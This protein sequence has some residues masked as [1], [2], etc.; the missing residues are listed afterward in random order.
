[1]FPA[2]NTMLVEL[3][4]WPISKAKNHTKVVQDAIEM[5]MNME[6]RGGCGCEPETGDG[7]GILIQNPHE[8]LKEECTNWDLNFLNLVSMELG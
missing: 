3:V 6:H 5:F 1:M 8:F 4:L 2:W 7:A